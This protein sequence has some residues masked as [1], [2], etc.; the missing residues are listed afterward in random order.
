MSSLEVN[1]TIVLAA[2]GV[3]LVL[4]III[5]MFVD[6]KRSQNGSEPKQEKKQEKKKEQK[7]AVSEAPIIE[8]KTEKR[9]I[10]QPDGPIKKDTATIISKAGEEK[11]PE[12]F[13]SL[14]LKD[15]KVPV[16]DEIKQ[17]LAKT[18]DKDNAE[19][20][21]AEK[22]RYL[23]E[24]KEKAAEK[25][26]E[27]KEAEK[28]EEKE[29]EESPIKPKIPLSNVDDF[30]VPSKKID[31][32][33]KVMS[34]EEITDILGNVQDDKE[35]EQIKRKITKSQLE[36][37]HQLD[38]EPVLK[39]AG[40]NKLTDDEVASLLE[41]VSTLSAEQFRKL[42]K[43]VQELVATI[44]DD[45]EN[46]EVHVSVT[47]ANDDVPRVSGSEN[48]YKLYEYKTF[49]DGKEADYDENGYLAVPAG[50]T[51]LFELGVQLDVPNG[52]MATLH[53]AGINPRLDSSYT[54]TLSWTDKKMLSVTCKALGDAVIKKG[55][56]VAEVSF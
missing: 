53:C 28:E 47:Y 44:I 27:E 9:P 13:A 42:P 55:A 46:S 12:D 48:N 1:P 3:S 34:D 33:I 26:E 20:E 51:V 24:A 29:E 41:M 31:S 21:L 39:P 52:A 36:E 35:D 11:S 4:A 10:A 2:Y 7:Q 54:E 23:Q 18:L 56:L 6:N 40:D 8:Q 37:M 14:N 43:D 5:I 15:D 16:N 17:R 38:A 49:V 19:M 30:F 22:E 25:E 45:I 32:P 50:S